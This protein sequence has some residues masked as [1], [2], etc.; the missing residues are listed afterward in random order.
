MFL[1]LRLNSRHRGNLKSR[2]AIARLDL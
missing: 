2:E 1:L